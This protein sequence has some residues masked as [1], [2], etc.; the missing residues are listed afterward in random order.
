[1]TIRNHHCRI[2]TVAALLLVFSLTGCGGA[3]VLR[4]P[5]PVERDGPVAATAGADLEATLEWVIVNNGPGAWVKHAAWDEYHVRIVNRGG[6]TV[7]LRDIVVY[8]MLDSRIRSSSDRRYLIRK[9]KDV[10]K[11]YKDHGVHVQAGVGTETLMT[12][13]AVSAAVGIGTAVAAP[14]FMS[15]AAAGVAAT[16]ILLAPVLATGGIVSAVNNSKIAYE[17]EDRST[18]LPIRLEAGAAATVTAFYPVTPSP[19]KVEVIYAV[20]GELKSLLIETRELLAGLHI[21]EKD[22]RKKR[23]YGQTSWAH[24]N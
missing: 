7:E 13:G 24:R 22:K 16:G 5:V 9:S 4:E 18:K 11:Q 10:G 20:D 1:M 23:P 3:K 8:D 15:T 17:I 2:V 21:G 6:G 19:T 14:V 12:A